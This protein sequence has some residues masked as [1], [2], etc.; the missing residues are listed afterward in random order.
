V[1][2]QSPNLG[3]YLEQLRKT[4][5]LGTALLYLKLSMR[6][7]T[8]GE[9]QRTSQ[10]LT[11]AAATEPEGSKP[12]PATGC[13]PGT[14]TSTW[15]LYVF[16][17]ST[18]K[19]VKASA[20]SRAP[21]ALPQHTLGRRLGAGSGI[22]LSLSELRWSPSGPNGVPWPQIRHPGGPVRSPHD[23][24]PTTRGPR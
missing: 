10:Q 14:V 2:G 4:D 12:K 7:S 17:V 11:I 9:R 23:V 24:R 13:D 22:E 19:H 8:S 20:Q 15:R 6:T 3:L 18:V 16:A 1:E 21:A 5:C